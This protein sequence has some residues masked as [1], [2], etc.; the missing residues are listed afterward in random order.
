MQCGANTQQYSAS[1]YEY[2]R[3]SG[4]YEAAIHVGILAA[5]TDNPDVKAVLYALRDELNTK[6][7]Q[8]SA[9]IKAQNEVT[10]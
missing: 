6:A 1:D 9:D 8:I 10:A 2:G 5:A 4:H 3:S 7:E